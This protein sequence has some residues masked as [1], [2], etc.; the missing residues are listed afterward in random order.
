MFLRGLFFL[1]ITSFLTA[2]GGG[3]SDGG[4]TTV[5]GGGP[6]SE[7]VLVDGNFMSSTF[8]GVI[9]QEHSK[10]GSRCM[11]YGT[12]LVD[13]YFES[14]N[15]IIFTTGASNNDILLSATVAEEALHKVA[16]QL[17]LT[18][19]GLLDYRRAYSD[20]IL[21]AL[22]QV[23]DRFG[24][25]LGFI[26]LHGAT[27]IPVAENIFTNDWTG[28]ERRKFYYSYWHDLSPEEQ[29]QEIYDAG[30]YR[31]SPIDD[32]ELYAVPRKIQICIADI[33]GIGVANAEGLTLIPPS[34]LQDHNQQNN[35]QGFRR[36]VWHEMVHVTGM[37]ITSHFYG[38]ASTDAWYAE[39]LAEY[40]SGGPI[41]SNSSRFNAVLNGRD[42]TGIQS[43][44]LDLGVIYEV[45]H[46]SVEYLFGSGGS[47]LAAGDAAILDLWLTIRD[48]DLR[49]GIYSDNNI[50][51]LDPGVP[52][53]QT[54]RA[55]FQE[56]FGLVFVRNG[57]P[58]T[59]AEYEAEY[60]TIHENL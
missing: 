39:G 55:V 8:E 30:I 21:A 24:E 49:T 27:S 53:P 1:C 12:P 10:L 32:I 59:Y 50:N 2:C 9:F 48:S 57:A 51:V 6:S 45:L 16:S 14:E 25:E 58:F 15:F 33:D 52:L 11:D 7:L 29:L 5:R 28:I 13:E 26:G 34:L 4:S 38:A 47:R 31:G 60:I 41:A 44:G 54:V 36:I 43:L 56:A 3:S 22:Y 46:S 23:Y 40:M 18:T 19:S 37:I 42:S 20:S 35:Y 17:N